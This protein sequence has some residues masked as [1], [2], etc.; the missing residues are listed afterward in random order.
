MTKKKGFEQYYCTFIKIWVVYQLYSPR[1]KAILD[2]VLWIWKD[3]D[4]KPHFNILPLNKGT[5]F[6]DMG[7][8]NTLR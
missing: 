5:K 2:A 7:L 4:R 6:K 8:N 3:R 1:V